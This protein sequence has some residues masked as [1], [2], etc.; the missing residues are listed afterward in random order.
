MSLIPINYQNKYILVLKYLILKC[1]ALQI[2]ASLKLFIQIT[3]IKSLND[4]IE[5]HFFFQYYQ[6]SMA[7]TAFNRR[8]C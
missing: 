6:N 1:L 5:F 2:F 8:V 7:C 4:E 3:S